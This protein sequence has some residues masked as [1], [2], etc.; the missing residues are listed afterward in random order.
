MAFFSRSTVTP[1]KVTEVN[2]STQLLLLGVFQW[3]L[4]FALLLPSPSCAVSDDTYGKDANISDV[5]AV[6]PQGQTTDCVVPKRTG[7]HLSNIYVDCED[8]QL[9]RIGTKA[10]R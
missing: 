7:R 1:W 2:T 4:H 5:Y 9:C 6:V 3:L 10:A 8:G